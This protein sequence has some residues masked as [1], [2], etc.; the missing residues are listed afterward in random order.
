MTTAFDLSILFE[1]E[2]QPQTGYDRGAV[3]NGEFIA[4][5]LMSLGPTTINDVKHLLGRWRHRDA[6]YEST[7]AYFRPQLKSGS[8]GPKGIMW[9][10]NETDDYKSYWKLMIQKTKLE[11]ETETWVPYLVLT[12]L[13]LKLALSALQ[14]ISKKHSSMKQ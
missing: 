14:K 11:S 1:K 12:E 6:T 3:S 5:C 2:I 4:L 13:G 9:V 8:L 7:Q 10:C